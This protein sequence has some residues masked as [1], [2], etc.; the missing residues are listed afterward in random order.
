MC[1]RFTATFE[2]SDMRVRWNLD[3]DLPLY[4]PRFNIAPEQ[5]S[6]TIPV[7]VRHK[8]GNECRLMH[9]GLIPSWAKDPSI[10]NQMINARAESLTEKPAFKDLV[11]SRRCII[12]A[13]G[14][15]EWRKE[16]KRKVPMWVH[17]KT[18]EPFAFAGL[19][20]VWRKPDGKRVESFTIITTEPNE[21]VRPVH[22]RMPVILRPEDEEQWLDVSRTS[23]AKA[24]SLL[25]PYPDELMD[26]HDVSPV[27]NSGKYD[28]PECVQP[29]SYDEI[30]SGR[31]LSL[32]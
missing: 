4:K 22:N 18:K 7:I 5:T 16:G 3:R 12:P 21:L 11:R 10:G 23:F 9:W 30:P 8:G 15:Y 19:W 1:G 6:P 17:L 29:V 32:L 28:G 13:D 31:Q 20:D 24:K 27:V 2:F 14:F 25:K 26:A